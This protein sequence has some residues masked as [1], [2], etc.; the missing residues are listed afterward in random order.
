MDHTR[1]RPDALA[2]GCYHS[3]RVARIR[4]LAPAFALGSNAR[5]IF[6]RK[7]G[8]GASHLAPLDG[9]R[10]LALVWVIL[11]HAGWYAWF[12][13]PLPQYGA[14]LFAP[15]MIFFWRGDF[16]VEV[17]F[18]M[19]AFLIGG[20]ITEEHR[21]TGKVDVVR[22]YVRRLYR[23]W[24]ALVVAVLVEYAVGEGERAYSI[25]P[26]VLYVQNLLSITSVRMG[27]TWSLAIE[28]QFYLTVPW[29]L[30]ALRSLE[31]RVRRALTLDP[32]LG[33]LGVLALLQVAV[34]AAIVV[35]ADLHPEDSEVVI[36]RPLE[37]W[38]RG[39]DLLYSKPWMRTGP[40]L[41]GLGCAR[42]WRVPGFME[43]LGRTGWRGTL[44]L[45]VAFAA[46]LSCMHWPLFSGG[47]RVVEVLY[48]ST[49][50]TVFGL[51]VGYGMLLVLSR[52]PVGAA[53]G[54]FLS[55]PV[56][57][58]VAQLAYCAYLVNPIVA[59]QTHRW[60][61]PELAGAPIHVSFWTWAG[62]DLVLTFACA[63]ALSLLVERPF[64]ELRRVL[65]PP[66]GRAAAGARG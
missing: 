18:V 35:G 17:F 23:L 66:P 45:V 63:I 30:G 26:N 19:S 28:E 21:A 49:Y 24:P 38:A 32:V 10:A 34:I 33:A 41:V 56:F 2:A 51:A 12:A 58:P 42:L 48:L 15:W 43:R 25:W 59:T 1:G 53:L 62:L 6:L 4:D 13:L 27:W 46:G 22:F 65:A 40:L 11:C 14:L 52:H 39:Y 31:A 3:A 60:L 64:M 8:A 47:S 16:A 54:R 57:Y 7:A 9:L 20:L 29:L 55:A 37:D 61:G 50:R 36:N 44:G 5:R